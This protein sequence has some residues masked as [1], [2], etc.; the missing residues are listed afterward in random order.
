[1][2]GRTVDVVLAGGTFAAG[3]LMFATGQYHA[4]FDT[5]PHAVL[6]VPL[7]VCSGALL[8]RRTAPVASV[9]VGTAA[10]AADVVLGPS[11]ATPLVYT[12]VLYDACTHGRAAL[13]RVLLAVSVVG[14]VVTGA[15]ALVLDPHVRSLSLAV[16]L[17][18]VTVV[19]VLTGIHVRHHRDQA[20]AARQLARLA[21]ADRANAVAAE[22]ARMAR[23]LHDVIANHLSAVAIHATAALSTDLGPDGTRQALT[24]IREN[25][26]QGLAEMR[27][28][29]GYLRDPVKADDPSVAGLSALDDLVARARRAGLAVDLTVRGEPA[30]L[31]A[32]VDRAAYRILQ[33]S[34][35]NALK[36]GD[37]GRV[38]LDL[39][40]TPSAI[41][42]R[43][44]STPAR[45][46]AAPDGAGSGV[47]GMQERA[48]LLGGSLEAGPSG[49]Q[50]LVSARL[51][52]VT[53]G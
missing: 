12:Q 44:T 21:E 47:V 1:M 26:V 53:A 38:G 2:K 34:L 41:G 29:I 48:A 13:T 24:V 51:P 6:L 30:E 10:V 49:G 36:H 27:Q 32:G 23:E 42:L 28:M 14:C 15:V 8:L 17:A 22:R 20:S 3:M 40:Y 45:T 18:L 5:L 7:A 25:S 33:E 50:W 46:T 37:G 19:P 43:V 39:E 52:L 31:P 16:I 9:L 11:L 4:A 35:T